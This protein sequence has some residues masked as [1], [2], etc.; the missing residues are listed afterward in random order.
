MAGHPA[1]CPEC[2][3][4]YAARFLRDESNRASTGRVMSE[5]RD[6]AEGKDGRQSPTV[7]FNPYYTGRPKTPVGGSKP[8]QI[9][10]QEIIRQIKNGERAGTS[11]RSTSP[12]LER[13]PSSMA[14]KRKSPEPQQQQHALADTQSTSRPSSRGQVLDNLASGMQ[15]ERPR[16]ALHRGD[17]REKEDNTSALGRFAQPQRDEPT[18][19][20]STS[21][22]PPWHPEFP[23]SAFRQV[24]EQRRSTAV[25]IAPRSPTARPVRSRAISNASLRTSVLYQPPTSPLVQSS[26]PDTPEPPARSESRSP[27][28]P[29]RRTFSPQLLQDYASSLQYPTSARVPASPPSFRKETTFPYQAHQPRRSLDHFSLPQTPAFAGRRPSF[30]SESPLQHAPMVGSYEESILRG[31]M[32]TTPSKPLNFV[33]QIGVLGKGGSASKLRCPPHASIPFPAVFY[34]YNSGGKSVAGDQPSPY[35][36]LIDLENNLPAAQS[37]LEKRRQRLGAVMSDDGSRASSQ[38]REDASGS[39]AQAAQRKKH[40]RKRQSG[41]PKA[42]PGG[43]YRIPQQGQLQIVIKNPNKTA[44]KLFLVPYDLSDMEPGQKTFVRQRSYSA[45]PIVDMPLSSRKNRGTDRP[46]AALPTGEDPNDRPMLRYLIHLHICCP[47]KGRFFLYKSIRVVFANRVPDGKEKLRN[48]I[49]LPEPRY[50][51]YKPGRNSILGMSGDC[52]SVGEG[53]SSATR[54]RSQQERDLLPSTPPGPPWSGRRMMAKSLPN[55]G[56]YDHTQD[57]I[58]MPAIPFDFQNGFATNPEPR[59]LSGSGQPLDEPASVTA[60]DLDSPYPPDASPTAVRGCTAPYEL[61]SAL[62]PISSH[63]SENGQQQMMIESIAPRLENAFNFE[64]DLSRERMLQMQREGSRARS[65]SLLSK[66]LRDLAV[67]NGRA[68]AGVDAGTEHGDVVDSEAS[69]SKPAE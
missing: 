32:S 49:Q 9:D 14:R 25:S 46:E 65:E 30:S 19:Q 38:T 6:E 10:R 39:D 33:A 22:V 18:T 59:P 5:Q 21:P 52:S 63:S 48:E 56:V 45:G 50:S 7:V 8:A 2:N 15:I 11:S 4:S 12:E 55:E 36:G 31:R 27:D 61:F 60:M 53:R 35:V 3:S 54:R 62:S 37:S 13:P 40:R 23:T 26:R 20:L 29:R 16:S 69:C 58:P 41:S 68:G 24:L 1:D 51:A 66:R 57:Q 47:S 42:P 44:V 64:R 34:S 28:R 67:Q 43:S 17:F